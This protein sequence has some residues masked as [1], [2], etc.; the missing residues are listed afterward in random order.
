MGRGSCW[1]DSTHCAGFALFAGFGWATC[2]AANI[3]HKGAY[4][5]KFY[6]SWIENGAS[7]LWKSGKVGAGYD[8]MIDLPANAQNI[9]LNAQAM[10]GLLAATGPADGPPAR[11]GVAL[12]DVL[13]GMHAASA[14]EARRRSSSST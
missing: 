14:G 7:K 1:L 11:V 2:G 9:N 4:V 5:A 10:T 3:Y 8:R 6:L 13:T 12:I